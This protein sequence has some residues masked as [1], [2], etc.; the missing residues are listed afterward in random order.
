MKNIKER[1]AWRMRGRARKT[2]RNKFGMRDREK[3]TVKA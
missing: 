2:Q 3:S 1:N